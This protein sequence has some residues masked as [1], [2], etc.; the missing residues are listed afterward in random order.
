MWPSASQWVAHCTGMLIASSESRMVVGI[1]GA[2]KQ[3]GLRSIAIERNPE[4][5]H[6]AGADQRR[7]LDDVFGLDVVEGAD[8][9]VGAPAAPVPE[10][11]RGLRDRL[12]ADGDVHG[13]FLRCG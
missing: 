13:R 9:V 1:P 5:E 4:R 2:R 8:L 3:A 6:L 7:R 12:L 11:L 10:L